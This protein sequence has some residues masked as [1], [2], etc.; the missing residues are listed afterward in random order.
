MNRHDVL[1]AEL[2]AV[3]DRMAAYLRELSLDE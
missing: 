2:G 1:R 3:E